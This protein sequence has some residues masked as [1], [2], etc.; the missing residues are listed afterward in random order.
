M[1]MN[2]GICLLAEDLLKLVANT[3]QKWE[4]DSSVSNV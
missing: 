2:G 4:G 3:T 1:V